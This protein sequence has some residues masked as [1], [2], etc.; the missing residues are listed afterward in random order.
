MSRSTAARIDRV[1][2]N[3]ELARA[4]SGELEREQTEWLQSLPR[5]EL[6]ALIFEPSGARMR[7]LVGSGALIA[8]RAYLGV[9]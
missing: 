4:M 6:A 1:R 8:L 9:R 2:R 5:D 7:S 3:I